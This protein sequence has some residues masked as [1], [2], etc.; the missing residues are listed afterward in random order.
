MR[1]ANRLV[2]RAGMLARLATAWGR[3]G[4]DFLIIGG[5]KCGT[6]SLYQYLLRHPNVAPASKRSIRFFDHGPNW[7]KGAVWYRS[8]FPFAPGRRTPAGRP[9]VGEST[10]AYL[11][12][13]LGAAR[14]QEVAPQARLIVLLR[15]PVDR[16]YSHYHHMYRRG[17]EPLPFEEALAREPERLAADRERL[18]ADP[19]HDPIHLRWH[20]YLARGCYVE[21]LEA[22]LS[23]VDRSR[24]LI[25]LTEELAAE[26]GE[27]M[28]GTHAFL[29]LPLVRLTDYPRFNTGTY[30]PLTPRVREQI[31]AHFAPHNRRLADLLGRRLGWD[32]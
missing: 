27:V 7:A 22:W 32:T 30:E 15:N 6:T 21:Q 19:G 25:I 16:A 9:L 4:P 18:A 24:M 26:P 1:S 10:P 31:A 20:S 2:H 23:R 29:G 12:H 17:R 14:V 11:F 8:H 28:A 13:P 3:P 5:Q